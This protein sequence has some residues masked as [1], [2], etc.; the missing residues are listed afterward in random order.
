MADETAVLANKT[1]LLVVNQFTPIG[2]AGVKFMVTE[3]DPTLPTDS[4]GAASITDGTVWGGIYAAEYIM[5]M[6]TVSSMLY[7]GPHSIVSSAGV[8]STN[9]HYGDVQHAANTNTTI[10]TL[11]LDFGFYLAAQA[12]GLAVLNGVINQA[13]LANNTT[14]TGGVTVPATGISQGVP[15]LY[16]MSYSNATGGLSLVIDN[17][18]ATAQQVT[19]R[20][21]GTPSNGPLSTQFI[22][23]TDPSAANTPQA[24]N[25]VTI[26]TA[27]SGNPVTVPPYSVLRVDLRTPAI[28]SF[29]SSASYQSGVRAPQE[30]VAAF[31]SGFASQTIVA[32]GQP[33]PLALGDTSIVIT[34]SKGSVSTAPLYYVSQGQAVFLIPGG[35]APGAATVKVQRSGATVLTGAMTI[36]SVSPGIYSANG[37]GAGVAAAQA[38]RVDASNTVTPLPV[39][40][41]QPGIVLSCLSTPISLGAST[42]SIFVVL[43]GTGI[44]GAK[45]VQAFVAGQSVPVLFAGAEGQDQGLDQVNITIP[46]ALAGTGE[47]SVYLVAD[48]ATSNMTTIRIQ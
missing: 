5:R 8:L 3:F 42:D 2:P 6:S 22:T 19:V 29:V 25:T 4:T 24:P 27:S 14:V 45:S 38:G 16:A 35:V 41:C 34:D 17:K 20:V 23:A 21:N 39:F 37:N 30:L 33:L 26:Q 11:S 28:A 15:A 48:G 12:N 18:S 44:R 10:D 31:G 47:A 36:A 43:Y 9:S 7:V 32:P 46:R 13:T 1:N 40:A